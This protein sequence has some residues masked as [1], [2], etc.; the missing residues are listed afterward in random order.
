MNTFYKNT[1]ALLLILLSSL[2]I[3]AQEAVAKKIVKSYS[4]TQQ[5]DLTI[6]SKYGDIV[7]NGWD[8]DS[9][10]ITANI[11][12]TDK[13]LENAK[14]LLKRI[15]PQI[16][17]VGNLAT[18]TSEIT[19]KNESFIANYFNKNNPLDFDK[20][21]VQINYTIYLPKTCSLNITNKFGDIILENFSGRLV[22]NLQ[23]GDMWINQDLTNASVDL[24]YG[25]LKT[26]SIAYAYIDLKNAALDM[27]TSQNLILNSSGSTVDILK[28]ISFEIISNKDKINI[29][30]VEEIRGK[31]AF[32]D[33]KINS[34]DNEINLNMKITDFKVSNINK[35]EAFVHIDQESSDININI[36]GLAFKFKAN[37]EQGVL[38]I[39][40]SFQNIKTVM[41]NNDLKL[42][43]I[44]ATYG[45]KPTGKFSI[46]GKKGTI[47]LLDNTL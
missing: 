47:L 29:S 36:T 33:V 4:L 3:K 43:E 35:P 11:K 27:E 18:I 31:I 17:I 23:H 32:S 9:I 45:K 41:I 28:I 13:K 26:K 19:A 40:K 39:P 10:V 2:A 14:D 25:K 1:A 7:V 5:G 37:L 16:K 20:T 21:N 42:R 38:R 46:T 24:K 8:K 6:D 12:V 30:S 44:N 22:T 15:Q 34:L